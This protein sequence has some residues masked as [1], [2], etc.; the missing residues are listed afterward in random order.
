MEPS[1]YNFQSRCQGFA[2]SPE[3]RKKGY[4]IPPRK[5][6]V[7]PRPAKIGKTCGAGR[8]GAKFIWIPWKLDRSQFQFDSYVSKKSLQCIA[9]TNVL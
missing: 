1:C 5:K 6:Q 8:G 9:S 2:S 4:P 3:P 7:L